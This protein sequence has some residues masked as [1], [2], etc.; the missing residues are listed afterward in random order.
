MED[1]FSFNPSMTKLVLQWQTAQAKTG[2]LNSTDV[3]PTL[4]RSQR[5]AQRAPE[6]TGPQSPVTELSRRRPFGVAIFAVAQWR[7]FS[8]LIRH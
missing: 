1:F 6:R 3:N 8:A 5:G 4:V 7:F 2:N